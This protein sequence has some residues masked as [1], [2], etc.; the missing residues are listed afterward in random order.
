MDLLLG[1]VRRLSASDRVAE[2]TKAL[3]ELRMLLADASLVSSVSESRNYASAAA[4]ARRILDKMASFIASERDSFA[5]KKAKA[6]DSVTAETKAAELARTLFAIVAAF[7]AVPGC[8][9]EA[10]KMLFDHAIEFI[11][12]RPG[13]LFRPFLTYLKIIRMLLENKAYRDHLTRVQWKS[14]WELA[15]VSLFT[16]SHADLDSEDTPIQFSSSDR[17]EMSRILFYLSIIYPKDVH[18]KALPVISSL[19][20][21]LI[22]RPQ[23]LSCQPPLL[24]TLIHMISEE[25]ANSPNEIYVILS[26]L[27]P[28]IVLIWERNQFRDVFYRPGSHR[29]SLINILRFYLYIEEL[30]YATNAHGVFQS[31]FELNITSVYQSTFKELHSKRFALFPLTSVSLFLSAMSSSF[32]RGTPFLNLQH[33]T[34]VT[35]LNDVDIN[36]RI[37]STWSFIDLLSHLCSCH[38]LAQAATA[39]SASSATPDGEPRKRR[40]FTPNIPVTSDILSLLKP[41]SSA[42]MRTVGLQA[43]AVLLHRLHSQP[44]D[45]ARQL[46]FRA[47]FD[48]LASLLAGDGGNAWVYVSLA[49]LARLPTSPVVGDL[50]WDRVAGFC[51]ARMEDLETACEGC[52]FLAM[53]LCVV[54]GEVANRMRRSMR[55]WCQAVGVKGL[56]GFE[57]FYRELLVAESAV[58][59][60]SRIEINGFV[61]K[62]LREGVSAGQLVDPGLVADVI[63]NLSFGSKSEQQKSETAEEFGFWPSYVHPSERAIEEWRFGEVKKAAAIVL[64][65]RYDLV[66]KSVNRH[67]RTSHN[68]PGDASWLIGQ[69]SCAVSNFMDTSGQSTVSQ[70]YF[71]SVCQRVLSGL[72]RL[73][74]E[75]ILQIQSTVLVVFSRALTR[76]YSG[77]TAILLD[78][79]TSLQTLRLLNTLFDRAAHRTAIFPNPYDHAKQYRKKDE[80]ALKDNDSMSDES[81]FAC[82]AY[83][84]RTGYQSPA[85]VNVAIEHALLSKVLGMLYLT[86]CESGEDVAARSDVAA[87]VAGNAD[88]VWNN[89]DL[90]C[91]LFSSVQIGVVLDTLV[92]LLSTFANEKNPWTWLSIIQTLRLVAKCIIAQSESRHSLSFV[93][94]IAFFAAE[95]HKGQVPWQV[96]LEFGSLMQVILQMDPDSNILCNDRNT[97]FFKTQKGATL[98]PLPF[99]I[100]VSNYRLFSLRVFGAFRMSQCLCDRRFKTTIINS[101]CANTS[102]IDSDPQSVVML[103][104]LCLANNLESMELL[105]MFMTR[106][107]SKALKLMA[108]LCSI[109]A[110]Y[111]P[112]ETTEFC[113]QAVCM[114]APSIAR[115]ASKF[116]DIIR[117]VEALPLLAANL[118]ISTYLKTCRCSFVTEFVKK[119]EFDEL[120]K[121]SQFLVTSRQEL[122][123]SCFHAIVPSLFSYADCG[124]PLTA[125]TEEVGDLNAFKDLIRERIPQIVQHVVGQFWSSSP[126]VFHFNSDRPI[127]KM[128]FAIFTSGA[129]ADDISGQHLTS[130]EVFEVLESIKSLCG[131]GSVSELLTPWNWFILMTELND[132]LGASCIY[133]RKECLARNGFPLLVILGIDSMINP[134][135]LQL[136][137]SLALNFLSSDPEYC[138]RVVSSVIGTVDIDDR[139]LA[140]AIVK[141]VYA[142]AQ[143]AERVA[144]HSNRGNHY[145][146]CL[147]LLIVSLKAFP[148]IV[149]LVF[150][151]LDGRNPL[152]ASLFDEYKDTLNHRFNLSTLVATAVDASIPGAELSILKFIYDSL[153]AGKKVTNP[154]PILSF[155]NNVITSSETVDPAAK[156]LAAR[157][158]AA[159][160][161]SLRNFDSVKKPDH[162]LRDIVG[163]LVSCVEG[164]SPFL[165]KPAI[166]TLVHILHVGGEGILA[167]VPKDSTALHTLE[168]IHT[169]SVG[170]FNNRTTPP[171]GSFN[172][173]LWERFETAVVC[174]NIVSSFDLEDFLQPLRRMFDIF[175]KITNATFPLLVH[176]TLRKEQAKNVAIA[177]SGMSEGFNKFLYNLDSQTIESISV[178]VKALT[179][180]WSQVSQDEQTQDADYWLD[181]DFQKASLSALKIRHYTTALLFY[182]IWL[183]SNETQVSVSN[184]FLLDV[185]KSLDRD[186]FSGV[187]SASDLTDDNM[188]LAYNEQKEFTKSLSLYNSQHM[189][190]S[191][192]SP[193]GSASKSMVTVQVGLTT[194]LSQLGCY[195]GVLKTIEDDTSLADLQREALWRCG[196][197]DVEI[198][199][200]ERVTGVNTFIFG[201]GKALSLRDF[202]S[203]SSQVEE[204]FLNLSAISNFS[205]SST[206]FNE[207][208]LSVI[209]LQEL[210]EAATVCCT[211]DS[212]SLNNLN[213]VWNRRLF[214]LLPEINFLNLESF[215]SSRIMSLTILLK[216]SMKMS[217]QSFTKSIFQTILRTILQYSKQAR[218]SMNP[219][220][221]TN[222]ISLIKNLAYRLNQPVCLQADF[223]H[224][225]VLF[226]QNNEAI[227][228]R[229]LKSLLDESKGSN[230]SAL[231]AKMFC[232]LGNWSDM[233]R[234]ENPQ[235]IFQF[236]HSSA[237]HATASVGKADGG[238]HDST[239]LSSCFYHFASFADK[240][241]TLMATNESHEMMQSLVEERQVEL[242]MLQERAKSKA[243]DPGVKVSIRRVNNQLKFDKLELARHNKEKEKYLL[244]AIENYFICLSMGDKWD[245]SAFSDPGS[246]PCG[247]QT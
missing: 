153:V 84:S 246:A 22:Q 90:N 94:I 69:V 96:I 177:R 35:G 242:S 219:Q 124:V 212:A 156:V 193:L 172:V 157:C 123:R 145:L 204:G 152:F 229:K 136:A 241:Y 44:D 24:A 213:D 134:L 57:S 106:A 21:C 166:D 19:A 143:N 99:I 4:D 121:L 214:V 155:L 50:D 192:L 164:A 199:A 140:A 245:I 102:N 127:Q 232:K 243:D 222:A 178:V 180:L 12:D 11:W 165:Q 41:G 239:K 112:K 120:T 45:V 190:A 40:K 105:Y 63:L 36:D 168:F 25:F 131:L 77:L 111:E 130:N 14:L 28:S 31:S 56:L 174:H 160:S 16:D 1:A 238:S 151:F 169:N 215:F 93:H 170:S 195:F 187:L 101:L 230:D 179:Y 5:A 163:L 176:S 17:L 7:H 110:T 61:G 38:L 225:K 221:S 125:L 129:G 115:N 198:N 74:P 2:R 83:F 114:L 194:S 138:S 66:V 118:N 144:D 147:N 46:D 184:S 104:S 211:A 126:C 117:L 139:G 6:K 73:F 20:D 97:Y 240:A 26:D 30:K 227:A 228:I 51:E 159:L 122:I 207:Q 76:M 100:S 60:A 81:F 58:F 149:A 68:K 108:V 182:E 13:V 86:V 33:A 34:H 10:Y 89:L 82:S 15:C 3:G 109:E 150:V 54:D 75:T 203:A 223:E 47:L 141:V 197:W 209:K 39:T 226:T 216:H 188:V 132:T 78:D 148:E 71:L 183:S 234:S 88:M 79:S 85:A 70:I 220:F 27:V 154:I 158:L 67:G 29:V 107:S 186:A 236:F 167:S 173:A 92:E 247:C 18:A 142:V 43:L 206:T 52:S 233:R 218:K 133:Q 116:P 137:L 87:F 146:D 55:K 23:E 175:P 196:K 237:Q 161:A 37:I 98:L 244:Q 59:G 201:I 80:F 191:L 162:P 200:T 103:F 119:N 42:N 205:F 208:L 72:V 224:C 91:L 64:G 8:L 135:L 49:F 181:I 9:D 32:T 231:L 48:A 53:S 113:R 202:E 171:L 210:Q 95:L 62:I 189:A 65:E 217:Q 128:F 235:S 185:Y